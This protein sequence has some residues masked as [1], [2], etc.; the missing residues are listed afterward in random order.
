M[1]LEH[2]RQIL[3]DSGQLSRLDPLP[4]MLSLNSEQY[5]LAYK[6]L[7]R[8]VEQARFDLTRALLEPTPGPSSRA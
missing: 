4:S 1:E 7:D 2:L 6:A 3:I 5:R 8:W